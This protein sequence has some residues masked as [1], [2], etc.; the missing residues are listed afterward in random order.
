MVIA[1]AFGQGYRTRLT[2]LLGL[3]F[4]SKSLLFKGW[5]CYLK[6]IQAGFSWYI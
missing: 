5:F 6:T 3:N 4:I 2:G 1:F